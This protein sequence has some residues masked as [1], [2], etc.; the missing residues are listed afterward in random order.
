MTERNIIAYYSGW[1]SKPG[2]S[3]TEI[4]DEDTNGFMRA[5][6]GLDRDKGLDL[7]LHTPGGGIA[8]THS[9]IDYLQNI[10]KK[11]IRAFV[12]HMAMSG[13]TV[14]ALSCREIFMGKHSFIGPIDPQIG[15]L[16]A[17]GILKD[18]ERAFEE[19]SDDKARMIVWGPILSKI[20]PGFITQCE[21]AIALSKNF[22]K[23][24]LNSNM[25][26]DDAEQNTKV[27][28]IITALTENDSV[29]SHDRHIS[30]DE[31]LDIGIKI[32]MLEEDS[33]LQDLVLTIHHC[34][35]HA[36][37]NTPTFKIIE[38]HSGGAFIKLM[39]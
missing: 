19:V 10:F 20:S 11:N 33:K 21:N 5:V 25:F 15:G 35:V 39:A 22:T 38:N 30:C 26:F 36:L 34:Y 16:P 4:R 6:H 14:M 9:I 37:S 3:G 2:V 24:Q 32:K 27:A 18:F 29:K 12:P 13:G 31:A 8:A 17:N 28:K 1:Q 23:E 7:I